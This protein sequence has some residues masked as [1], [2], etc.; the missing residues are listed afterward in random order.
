[1]Q[2]GR[3][4]LLK[5]LG[6]GGRGVVYKA[7]DTV[8]DRVVAIKTLKS[9]TSAGEA[10]SRFIREAQAVGRLNYPNI[11]SVYD[12]GTEAEMQFLVLEFVDGGCLSDLMATYPDGK[13]DVQT[14]LRIGM[15]I[16]SA[17]QYA[18]SQ[19][20]LHRDIKPQNIMINQ[21]GVAKLMDFGLAKMLGQSDL[22][23]EGVIVGTVAYVAPE[24]ALGKGADT[25]SDLY[26][27]G[28][29]LYEALTGKPPFQGDDPVR[30]I[31]SHV[32]D[33]PVPP[34]KLDP[35]IPQA[36]SECIMQLL[37]K[38]PDKRYRS[39]ADLLDSL[40]KI[41]EG[42]VKGVP[43]TS[44]ESGVVVP[45][46]RPIALKEVRLV[47]RDE[48]MTTLREAVDRT[49]GGEGRVV[50]LHG[51]AGIG[52]TRLTRELGAYARLRGMQVLHGRCP[53][54]F[55]MDGVPPYSLW[56]EVIKDYLEI[57]TPEQLYRAMGFYPGEVSKLVPEI[58]Q[59]LGAIPPSLPIGPE[60]ER[61]RLF[62]A[63][64][65]LITNISKEIPLL[66]VLDDLQWT[67]Q[68][69]IMLLD[70]LARGVYRTPLLMLGAYR[71]TD[72]DEKHPLA[73]VMTELDRA[74]VLQSVSLKRMSLEDVSEIV[75]RILDQEDVPREFC[76]SVYEKARGN[77]FFVEEVVKSL[78]EEGIIHRED[79]QWKIEQISRIQFPKTVKAV[80]KA[81]I[82]RLDD[83]CQN[84]LTLASFIGNSFT[85]EALSAVT[86]IGEDRLLELMDRIVK[87]G[88]V[89]ENVI[90][91]EDV[92]SFE[93]IIVRD[94]LHEEVSH[95]RHKKIHHTVGDALEKAYATKI[96]EHSGEL[97][98]HF[99]EGGNKDKALSYFMKA[100]EN[101]QK[102]YAHGEAISYLQ[103]ALAL[104][105]E[106]GDN[107]EAKARI[108]ETLGN[109]EAWIGEPDACMEYWNKSLEL[110]S[111][112]RDERSASRLHVSIARVLWDEL[113]EKDKASEHHR[114]ALQILEKEP[115]SLELANLYQDISHML[116]RTGEV[117]K[118]LPYASKALEMA[119]KL[120]NPETL[121]ECYI[122]MAVMADKSGKVEDSLEYAEKSLKI[123][124][125][126]N[127]TEAA[128]RIY[129]NL[130]VVYEGR[131]NFR[132]ALEKYEEAFELTKKVG[133]V[134][135]M[136]WAGLT[137]AFRNFL[138]GDTKGSMESCEEL[139][140]LNRRSK[141]AIGIA[142]VMTG[143]GWGHVLLGDWEKG[144]KYG[145][146]GYETAKK[147][148]D[149]QTLGWCTFNLGLSYEEMGEYVEA[150]NYMREG[151]AIFERA[152]DKST[153]FSD[154]YPELAFLHLRKGEADKAKELMEGICEYGKQ[155]NNR[156][157][158]ARGEAIRAMLLREQKDWDQSLQ[159]FEKSLELYKSLEMQEF[160]LWRYSDLLYEY[161]LAY[162]YRN[163]EGDKE[164][165]FSLLDQALQ[166]YQQVDAKKRMEKVLAKKKLMT[167]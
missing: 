118:A 30:I 106:K 36:L 66:L 155:T 135:F 163:G 125:E 25:R 40:K 89:K 19:G 67:D 13:C 49:L 127:C 10:H 54:L 84:V 105:E 48:E 62:E 70:Y 150:Q 107:V 41:A 2:Q 55:H 128:L 134:H 35:K 131:G 28:A 22:T 144:I 126:N 141:N 80:L 47:D 129:T 159:C 110:W 14:V 1:L 33:Y 137:L 116:W 124:V 77:P 147:T 112:L 130:G 72:I 38:D 149:Y 45:G 133:D 18:H 96:D 29:V 109:I 63:V 113:G 71:E 31:F 97:G 136:S 103:H 43:V 51:E 15:D 68:T 132:Q 61:D 65:Q 145:V 75:R 50:F 142:Q 86:G 157:I 42:F 146:E 12:V 44:Y 158:I 119:Q 108:T 11:V 165:A 151:I 79:N 3:Y 83:E 76:E 148:N 117:S 7:R 160:D 101:A 120:G 24:V 78:K 16:C 69:S 91:G 21:D 114:A 111:Q 154:M 104:V 93:D 87:T 4:T 64:S 153:L 166:I 34:A 138:R 88:M 143:L 56:S 122:D 23:R 98:F 92:Y 102:V 52:K 156:W 73:P 74:R 5:K 94:A 17:L 123:S 167:A 115:E 164:R 81:R 161:G 20:V 6:E 162:L 59:K 100:A 58:R 9:T 139:L 26:S 121:A 90:R 37:E 57:C 82:G 39:A 95:L 85:F 152:E 60:Q 32:H 99:L 140:A 8:L 46:P 53:A 27:L